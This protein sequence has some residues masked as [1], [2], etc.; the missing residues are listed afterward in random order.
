[1]SQDKK[2]VAKTKLTKEE[3]LFEEKK[4]AILT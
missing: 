1:M 2:A 4:A 3:K